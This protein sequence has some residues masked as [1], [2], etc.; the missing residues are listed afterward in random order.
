MTVENRKEFTQL[1]HKKAKGT[2]IIIGG[3]E[4][5]EG[6]C[7]ILKEVVRRVGKGQ[8]VIATVASMVPEELAADYRKVFKE[9]GLAQ[10]Q[11]HVFDA[12]TREDAYKEE[13]IELIKKAKVVFFTGGDQLRITS[14]IG[15]SMLFRHMTNLYMNGGTIVGTSAGAAAMSETM[16]FYGPSDESNKI[17]TLGMAPGLG[18]LR[19][20]VIDTHFAERGRMGRLLG[21]VAQNPKNM[22]IGIDENTSIIVEHEDQFRVM[23]S[24]A[25]YVVDGT[26]IGYTSLSEGRPEG[27]V[28]IHNAKIHVLGNGDKFDLQ[29]RCPITPPESDPVSGNGNHSRSHATVSGNGR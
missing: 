23:G 21:A 2:L 6:D 11:V 18:L 12:R 15:D 26:Q 25:V 13:Y 14:Q 1:L 7:A 8:L 5:K 10:K 16:L 20:L 28:T 29:S 19:E 22:G 27:I 3:R 24:G 17:S 4:E 9:L